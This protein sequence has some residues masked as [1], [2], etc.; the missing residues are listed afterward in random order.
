VQYLFLR[1]NIGKHWALKQSEVFLQSVKSVIAILIKYR[2]VQVGKSKKIGPLKLSMILTIVFVLFYAASMVPQVRAEATISVDPTG[3]QAG[4]TIVLKGDGFPILTTVY[5]YWGSQIITQTK[6]GPSS[7]DINAQF[8]VPN[9]V[10]GQ[11]TIIAKDT[12]GNSPSVLFTVLPG[13]TTPT[14]TDVTPEPSTGDTPEPTD[15]TSE[16]T[17]IEPTPVDS[18]FLNTTTIAIIAVV[19]IAVFIPLILLFMRRGGSKRDMYNQRGG[20]PMGPYGGGQPGGYGGGAPG[21]YGG[22]GGY[23][24]GPMQAPYGQPQYGGGAPPQYGR[25]QAYG[26]SPYARPAGYGGGAPGGYGGGGGYGGRPMGPGPQRYGP[27]PGGYGG[28]GGYGG[29]PMGGMGGGMRTCP[30]CRAPVREDQN[31]CP[32][33]RT[34]LR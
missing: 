31:V 7:T 9:T 18:G 29:R 27:A 13:G 20:E 5:I 32:N 23:G 22:G 10:P 4:D 14:P 17:D 25:P 34:R 24:Q 11:Y 33:C 21:G 26:P 16:P 28:G 15:E 6:T 12:A 19:L 3:G 8:P 2:C 1:S 30:N